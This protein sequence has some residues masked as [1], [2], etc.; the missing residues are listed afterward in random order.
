MVGWFAEEN[1]LEFIDSRQ[2]GGSWIMR[3]WGHRSVGLVRCFLVR[4]IRSPRI[5]LLMR[6]FQQKLVVLCLECQKQRKVSRFPFAAS[7]DQQ[8]RQTG[9]EGGLPDALKLANLWNPVA[10]VSFCKLIFLAPTTVFRC[11]GCDVLQCW[12]F[13]VKRASKIVQSFYVQLEGRRCVRLKRL[14]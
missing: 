1:Q 3:I 10:R 8:Q 11:R 2:H 7:F 4:K 12:I 5:L 9:P 6:K 13:F 14:V